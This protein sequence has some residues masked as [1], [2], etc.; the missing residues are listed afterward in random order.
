MLWKLLHH[1]QIRRAVAAVFR[2]HIA[3]C[4]SLILMHVLYRIS[5][6]ACL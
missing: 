6:K 1:A 2:K 5:L 3:L 4:S